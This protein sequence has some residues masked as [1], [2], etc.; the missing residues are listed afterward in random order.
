IARHLI[1]TD[2]LPDRIALHVEQADESSTPIWWQRA[3]IQEI[4]EHQP[5]RARASLERALKHADRIDTS[6]ARR[7][8]EFECQ[9]ILGELAA[10]TMGPG[11]QRTLHA[12]EA[13]SRLTPVDDPRAAL[14]GLWGKWLSCQHT[15]RYTEALD[16]ARR[17]MR[18]AVELGIEEVKGWSHYAIGQTYLWCGRLAEAEQALDRSI[19]V[20]ST[21]RVQE[22]M[23]TIYGDQ[24]VAL[25]Y[26]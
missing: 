8:F 7:Q 22:D 2:A 24:A 6:E 9:L 26:A 25:V 5:R 23:S 3:A 1:D 12:Y 4:R 17:H 14:L 10:A 19:A 15:A 16:L 21:V 20:L 18:L 11:A 13:A